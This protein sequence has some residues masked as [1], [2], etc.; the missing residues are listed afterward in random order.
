M[1]FGNPAWILDSQ[2]FSGWTFNT[3]STQWPRV[4]SSYSTGWC[5]A[6]VWIPTHN[7]LCLFCVWHRC[8]RTQRWIRHSLFKELTQ[9]V[10]K[11]TG[12]EHA[13][14]WVFVTWDKI[15]SRWE[16]GVRLTQ[17]E[18]LIKSCGWGFRQS[19]K[20]AGNQ[21]P[22]VWIGEPNKEA[23]SSKCK[24]PVVGERTANP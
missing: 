8:L 7:C 11:D 10:G 23:R 14:W 18:H 9:F 6:K 20:A 13:L 16:H 5:S 2:R 24:G 19:G 1:S 3:A 17:R 21:R 12:R 15:R 4:A 22:E